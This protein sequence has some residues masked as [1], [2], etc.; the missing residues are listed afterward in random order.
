MLSSSSRARICQQ[1]LKHLVVLNLDYLLWSLGNLVQESLLC[2]V[3]T[4]VLAVTFISL[5][6]VYGKKKS[7]KEMGNE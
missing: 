3:Q 7:E 4:V 2:R 6:V 5:A 1:S